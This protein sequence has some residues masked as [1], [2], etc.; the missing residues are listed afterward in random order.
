MTRCRLVCFLSILVLSIPSASATEPRK[1]PVYQSKAPRYG[2]LMLGPDAKTSL[3]IVFDSVPDPLDPKKAKDYL[4]VDRNGNGDLTEPG[5]RIEAILHKQK[6]NVSFYPGYYEATLL[7]FAVGDIEAA[8]GA[9]KDIKVMVDWYH[10]KDR[11]AT[12]SASHEGRVLY[13]GQVIFTPRPKD[14]PVVHLGG[15]L[16]INLSGD[17]PLQWERG[18]ET[19]LYA[20]LGTPGKG[21]GTF[22]VVRNEAVPAMVH[23]T[24]EIVFPGENGKSGQRM[25]VTLD[26][27]C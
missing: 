25:T 23:P 1:E 7:E 10:G 26:R 21:T 19:A 20:Y 24:A 6:I 2:L 13:T 14:A 15:K 16:M 11:P 27:R 8:G 5:E 4:Y 3:W 22:A 12:I 18:K 9:I 17:D